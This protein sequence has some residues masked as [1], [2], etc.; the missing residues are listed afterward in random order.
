MAVEIDAGLV[1]PVSTDRLCPEGAE[2]LLGSGLAVGLVLARRWDAGF[3][4][5]LGYEFWLLNAN[6][7]Y[8]VTVAQ[9][10]TAVLQYGFMQDR[11]ARPL[12]RA[13]GGLLLLGESFR[14]A[15]IGGMAELAVGAEIEF[16]PQTALTILLG[17]AILRTSEFETSRDGVER[18]TNGG[19]DGAI[20]LRIGYVFLL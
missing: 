6:D 15:T 4:V 2:C 17:G 12:I 10:V 8:D 18:A 11:A 16:S 20:A 13:R 1:V 5:G 9:Q 19:V 7:V 3:S 14:V